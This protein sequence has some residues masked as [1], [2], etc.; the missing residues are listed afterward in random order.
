MRYD[1]EFQ[2]DGGGGVI[3]F[4]EMAIFKKD[5]KSFFTPPEVFQ[6]RAKVFLHLLSSIGR[7][8]FSWKGKHVPIG[9]RGNVVTFLFIIFIIYFFAKFY[10][11][12]MQH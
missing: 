6:E 7:R 5:F 11:K 3:L 8:D 10:R 2:Y 1:I 12:K 9:F 4:A